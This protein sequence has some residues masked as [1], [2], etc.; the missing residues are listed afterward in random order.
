MA[1]EPP[2]PLPYVEE[3][4]TFH[5]AAITLAGTL[6]LPGSGAPPLHPAAVMITYATLEK[7][8][9]PEFLPLVAEWISER[10]SR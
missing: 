4:V 8:F 5:N 9:V 10:V 3:E 6:T 7:V 2:E 1:E